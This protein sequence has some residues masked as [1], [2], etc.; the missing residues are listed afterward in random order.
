MPSRDFARRPGASF[1]NDVEAHHHR[2]G[3]RGEGVAQGP[4]GLIFVPY[5][6]PAKQVAEVDGSRGTLAEVLTPSPDRIAPFCR[7]FAHC[8]GCAV[9]TLAAHSYAG[10]KRDLVTMSKSSSASG[11]ERKVDDDTGG[12]SAE[13]RAGWRGAAPAGRTSEMPEAR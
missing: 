2:L 9:Q 11:A 6:W 12:C 8:G 13:A 7:Y 3:S 1:R 4:D 10:W 5:A